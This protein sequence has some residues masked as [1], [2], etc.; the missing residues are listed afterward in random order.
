[1][2]WPERQVR[3]ADR[4]QQRHAV[5]AFPYAVAQSSVTQAPPTR[6]DRLVYRRLAQMELRRPEEQVNASFTDAADKDPLAGAGQRLAER[7]L[8]CH[9]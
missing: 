2:G 8:T 4:F 5:L 1:M 6:A 3:R 7:L 9:T